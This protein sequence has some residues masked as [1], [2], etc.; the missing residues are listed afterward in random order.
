[1]DWTIQSCSKNKPQQQISCY[2][3]PYTN[4]ISTSRLSP[5]PADA[6]D[7]SDHEGAAEAIAAGLVAGH[8]GGK[9]GFWLHT[10]GTGI[11][12]YT[13]ADSGKLGELSDKEY[14]DWS[15]VRELTS[16]PDHAFHRN[17]DKVVLEAGT[18]H[19]DVLKTVIV[20][21][22]TIYGKGRGPVSGRG[23][24]TYELTKLI[25]TKQYIP[26]IG[27]GKARWNHIHVADLSRLF[28]LLVEAAVAGDVRD[29]L[30]GE[31]GYMLIE[32]GEHWW[33]ELAEEIANQA[34]EIG[35]V[36]AKLEKRALEREA[37]IEQAGFEAESWGLNSRGKAERANKT[38]GWKPS[39]P[40]LL[41][42]VRGMIEEEHERLHKKA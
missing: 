40:S 26:I 25:L 18:K 20:C 7:A 31:Q 14:N 36:D 1:M 13:D 28:L 21:P 8:T 11:L 12:T 24:Q 9:P 42:S 29:E 41:D 3:C 16:L 30:W 33:A 32:S 37:A 4:P 17:V 10:G 27:A 19:R 2:V 34:G 38:L 5:E 15:G 23:R 6:A 39:A 22:P 35:Y